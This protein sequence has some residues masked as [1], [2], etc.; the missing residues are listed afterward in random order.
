MLVPEG[1][2]ARGLC[3]SREEGGPEVRALPADARDAGFALPPMSRATAVK[4]LQAGLL[5]AMSGT[6]ETQDSWFTGKLNV[7][8]EW[9]TTQTSQTLLGQGVVIAPQNLRCPSVNIALENPPGPYGDGS[10][11]EIQVISPSPGLSYCI[12][13]CKSDVVAVMAQR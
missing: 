4:F 6:S 12:W 7:G 11:A 5:K 13:Q 10:T 3:E 1:W 8:F 2:T 9:K